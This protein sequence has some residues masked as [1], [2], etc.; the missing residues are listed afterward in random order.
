MSD[1]NTT[2]SDPELGIHND[3]SYSFPVI[4]PEV[5]AHMAAQGPSGTVANI[6]ASGPT[7][8]MTPG[9]IR[10]REQARAAAENPALGA[11]THPNFTFAPGTVTPEAIERARDAKGK[12]PPR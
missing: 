6:V 11:N 8:G 10:D 5:R 9:E 2:P 7:G 12:L 4:T 1:P 3:L